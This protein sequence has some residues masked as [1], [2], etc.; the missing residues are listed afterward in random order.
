MKLSNFPVRQSSVMGSLSRCAQ[1]SVVC[2]TLGGCERAP[3]IN[4]LGAYF[5]SWMLCVAIGIALTLVA[6]WVLVAA[7]IDAALGPRGV[8]YPAL[9]LSL[10]LVAWLML[11]R[12]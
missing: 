1:A 7:G 9:A 2:L 5:P 8:V 4:L 12:G 11:F 10:S 3:S 6:R